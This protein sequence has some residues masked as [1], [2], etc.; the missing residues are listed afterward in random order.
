MLRRCPY[1]G[2]PAFSFVE[3]MGVRLELGKYNHSAWTVKCHNCQKESGRFMIRLGESGRMLI[4]SFLPLAVFAIVCGVISVTPMDTKT[5]MGWFMAA[6]A[7]LAITGGGLNYFLCYFDKREA[8]AR[9]ADAR[10]EMAVA[11]DRS[12]ED[13]KVGE[14]YVVRVPNRGSHQF[15][16]H[17]YGMVCARRKT[18]EGKRLDLRINKAYDMDLPEE[19]EP[20]W[21]V[22]HSDRVVEGTAISTRPAREVP[23]HIY[24]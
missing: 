18:A 4:A 5:K 9:E 6:V 13:A 23:P 2:E 7:G 12:W 22:T 14:I 20:I 16:P 10:V 1:C 19:G 8:I 15:A 11:A 17:F 3:K 24:E 21:V